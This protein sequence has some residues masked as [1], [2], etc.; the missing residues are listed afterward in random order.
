MELR[1][2]YVT[3]TQSLRRVANNPKCRFRFT[4]HA[5]EEMK[6][7]GWTVPDIQFALMNGHVV[8]HEIKKD[9]LWRVEGADLDGR[10]LTVIVA[11]YEL[12]IE[13]KVVTAF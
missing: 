5:L 12:A 10:R 9:L 1:P 8:L 13:I 6:S 11:V 2:H 7:D 3:E 4:V